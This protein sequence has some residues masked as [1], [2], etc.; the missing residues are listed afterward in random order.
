MHELKPNN[1]AIYRGVFEGYFD[2]VAQDFRFCEELP[3]HIDW[4]RC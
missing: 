3:S 4:V 1:A 2:R